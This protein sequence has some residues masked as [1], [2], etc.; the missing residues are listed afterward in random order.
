MMLK[1]IGLESEFDTLVIANECERAKPYPD[2]YLTAMKILGL[3]SIDACAIEDSSTGA[4]AA[5]AADVYTIGI[6]TSQPPEVLLNAGAKMAI[7]NY[8][9]LLA[10]IKKEI[11]S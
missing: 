10:E 1:G 5:V 4:S 9:E 11:A 8:H 2:P 3:N 7:N 6:M